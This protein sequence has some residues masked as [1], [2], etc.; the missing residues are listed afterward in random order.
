M[1]EENTRIPWIAFLFYMFA[2]G[3]ILYISVGNHAPAPKQLSY[4]EFVNEVLNGK[5]DAVRVTSTDLIGVVKATGET[6]APRANIASP[7]ALRPA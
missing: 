7:R 3:L 5:A 6:A 4:S 1:S 2:A